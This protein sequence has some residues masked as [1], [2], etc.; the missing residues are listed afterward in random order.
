[1]STQI[2]APLLFRPR[3]RNRLVADILP[4]SL[5]R[6]ID[7]LDHHRASR[8]ALQSHLAN[9]GRSDQAGQIIAKE[10]DGRSAVAVSAVT[11]VAVA[12]LAVGIATVFAL[13]GSLTCLVGSAIQFRHQ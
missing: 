2:G 12:A 9:G 7:S 10:L 1:M 6:V 5:P 4:G 3:P 8:L 13:F 11:I